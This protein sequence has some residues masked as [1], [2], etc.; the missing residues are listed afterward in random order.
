MKTRFHLF[1]LLLILF[2]GIFSVLTA[3][4]SAP[5]PDRTYP[6]DSL[7]SFWGIPLGGPGFS[8]D[9]FLEL[10][11]KSLL[12]ETGKKL[13]PGE[14]ASLRTAQRK[15]HKMLKK[16]YN[17]RDIMRELQT[18]PR[19]SFGGLLLG[20]FLGPVGILIAAL[21]I[22][23][24]AHGPAWIGFGLMTVVLGLAAIILGSFYFIFWWLLFLALL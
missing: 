18:R 7:T 13:R 20:F 12:L 5:A 17:E 1:P 15:A 22:G 6:P 10:T 21:G 11:P 16:G 4:A 23:K 3:N 24:H 9:E 2:L 14:R 8:L 19:F